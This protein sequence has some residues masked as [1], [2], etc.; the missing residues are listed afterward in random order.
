[1]YGRGTG[2]AQLI[3]GRQYSFVA[4][5]EPGR[6][7]WTAVFDAVRLQPDDDET[8]VTARQVRSVV[9]R[10]RAAGQHRDGDPDIL[11]I[12]DA[13]YDL[14]RL[15]VALTD[16]PGWIL[17]R[18][19]GDRV[20]C[21][22]ALPPGRTGATPARPAVPVRRPEQLAH[23]RGHHEHG[24]RPVRNGD[25]LRMESAEP[26]AHP[27][28]GVGRASRSTADRRGHGNPT[29]RRPSARKPAPGPG[30]AVVLG[31]HRRR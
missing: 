17:G 19:R 22:P 21:F 20:S 15:A 14:P 24:H 12:F 9:E 11:L 3:P 28:R 31:P 6:T 5:L 27:P 4:A 18:M 29:D 2:R 23:T 13:G 26:E 30:M 8:L 25:G 16:L 1:M 10:L 7:S